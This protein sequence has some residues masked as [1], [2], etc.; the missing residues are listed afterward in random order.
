VATL[1]SFRRCPYAIRARL[2]LAVSGAELDLVEV[3]LRDKPPRMLELSPKGTVP[4][5]ELDDGTVIEESLD[6]MLWTLRR[7]DPEGWLG[8]GESMLQ[9]M[10][11]LVED[12]D[13]DFKDH[14]DRTKYATR[15]DDA[16]PEAH[17]AAAGQFLAEL[18]SRLGANRYLM[19]PVPLL[20]D[21]ALLPFVR[22][23]ANIDRQRFDAMGTPLLGAWLDRGLESELFNTVMKKGS[24]WAGSDTRRRRS[25]A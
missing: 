9:E 15:Y 20:V 1:F 16:D 3:S 10:V 6:I 14:L 18:E 21:W 7:N 4:V 2:A 11:L 12:N 19:G 13:G 22:Q 24:R 5:V 8:S 23:F 17:R 25:P